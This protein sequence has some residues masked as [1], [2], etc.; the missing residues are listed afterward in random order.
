MTG[1]RGGPK[2]VPRPFPGIYDPP[3]PNPEAVEV[4]SEPEEPRGLIAD[5]PRID[6]LRRRASVRIEDRSWLS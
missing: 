4:D 3:G 6:P 1:R 2:F 5:V